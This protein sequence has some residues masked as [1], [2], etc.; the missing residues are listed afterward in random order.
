VARVAKLK[1]D[2][3]EQAAAGL[4]VLGWAVVAGLGLDTS[5]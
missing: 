5:E 3:F 4:H 1:L 2:G